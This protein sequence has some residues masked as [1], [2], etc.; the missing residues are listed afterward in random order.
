MNFN[1]VLF[2]IIN[3]LDFFIYFILFNLVSKQILTNF[4]VCKML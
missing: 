1:D 2:L 3:N 4:I